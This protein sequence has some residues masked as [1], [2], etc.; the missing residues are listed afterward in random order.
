MILADFIVSV[1]DPRRDVRV[2]VYDSVKGLRIAAS[3]YTNSD[4]PQL[5][6]QRGE[7]ANTLGVCHRFEWIDA[8]GNS[9]PLCAIVRL[10]VPNIG[11]GIISHE[12]CHAAVWVR[13]LLVGESP[14]TADDDEWFAW[15]LGDLVRQTVNGMNQRG[16]FAE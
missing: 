1:E 11:V 6:R 13:E 15:V 10:A 16:V 9:K 3:R 4:R 12:M 5:H 14:L 7:F 2:I 8:D